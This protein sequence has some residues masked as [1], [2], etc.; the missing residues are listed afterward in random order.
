MIVALLGAVIIVYAVLLPREQPKTSVTDEFLE[1]VGGTLQQFAD[2][3]E[4][5][6]KELLHMVRKM[7]QEHEAK[8]EALRRR[9]EQLEAR[10]SESLPYIA[11]EMPSVAEHE[12]QIQKAAS[13]PAASAAS[14]F[15][16][17]EEIQPL[18]FA[19]TVRERYKPLFELYDS[20]KSIEYIARKLGKNKGEVQLIISLAR[21]EE[22]RHEA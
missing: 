2:E 17:N 9:I 15:D 1:S 13:E 21:Q 22:S 14:S 20:G 8:V 7:K 6:N 10:S 16:G 12:P 18:T 4:E 3:L 5:E 11:A 19:N